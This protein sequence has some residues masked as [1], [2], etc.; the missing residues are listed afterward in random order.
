MSPPSRLFIILVLL[1]LA[2]GGALGLVQVPAIQQRIFGPPAPPERKINDGGDDALGGSSDGKAGETYTVEHTDYHPP[3]PAND[4]L[5]ADDALEQKNPSFDPNLVDRR[6]FEGWRI[7]ASSAVIRLDVPMILPDA[8]PHLLALHPSYA[9]AIRAAGTAYTILPSVNMI[10]GKAKQFDDGLYAALDQAYYQ[11]VE[12]ALPSHVRLI[13]SIFEKV[14]PD[15]P[16]APYL[17]AGLHFAGVEVAVKSE[18]EKAQYIQGFLADQVRSKPI[19]FYTWNT[20]LSDCF[21]FLRFFQAPFMGEPPTLKAIA[22]AMSKDDSLRQ[23]YQKAATFYGK[24]T[25][26]LR[27]RTVADYVAKPSPS[28]NVNPVAMFPGSSSRETE[29]FRALFPVSLPPD[30]DLMRELVMA[31]RSGKVDLTPKPNS[32]WYDYQVHALE[33]LL[34]PEKSPENQKLLLTKAYK[35]RMLEAFKALMTK[36]RETHVRQLDV[37][38]PMAMAER[39]KAKLTPRLRV[40]PNPTYYL[41]TARSYAFLASFLESS[42]GADA[43]KSLHGLR[44]QGPREADLY[45]ELT[46]MRELFYGMYL[47]SCEDIGMKPSFSAGEEVDA[48]RCEKTATAWLAAAAKDQDL[49]ADT[50]VSVPIFSDPRR[51]VTRLWMTIGV[52]MTKLDTSYARAPKMKPENGEGEWQEIKPDELAGASYLIAVDEFA[53]VELKGNRVLTREELR[54][55]CDKAKTKEKIVAELS[56]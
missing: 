29:L 49:A 20:T 48:E 56:R 40:E 38:A 3:K 51:G 8:E 7:N 33:T 19:G 30:A 24:L 46:S 15:S 39:P 37:A 41:R 4:D 22:E 36:R 9:A 55:V 21:R 17:A 44:Q 52:R 16:A 42:V 32:G 18:G 10:D 27:G 1:L 43:L 53:E 54:A 26:P 34:L 12:N 6:P 2:I 23:D 25:N 11:G 13:Q 28:T 5:L 47:L 31:I 35:K 45:T 50:R 14:G